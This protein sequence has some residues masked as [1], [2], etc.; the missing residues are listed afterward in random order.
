MKAILQSCLYSALATAIG[1]A[2]VLV[3]G[4]L[5]WAV[6]A[7]ISGILIGS[8]TAGLLALLLRFRF[9]VAT[10]V[11]ATSL[12]AAVASFFAIA[13]AE[14]LPP[15]SAEWMLKGGLYGVCFGLP[16]ALFLGP[17][18]LLENYL[19]PTTSSHRPRSEPKP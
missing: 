9:A 15:G 17:I 8:L 14:R 16:V 10:S 7:G 1:L 19:L 18:G 12:G 4:R 11:L 3:I 13:S 2:A 6:G 5:S